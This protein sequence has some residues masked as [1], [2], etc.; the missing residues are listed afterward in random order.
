MKLF[1]TL[2]ALS[3]VSP[4]LADRTD[5]PTPPNDG[6]LG[7]LICK[8][9]DSESSKISK[10]TVIPIGDG[11]SGNAKVHISLASAPLPRPEPL[12]LD[13]TGTLTTDDVSLSFKGGNFEMFNYDASLFGVLNF[14]AVEDEMFECHWD[15]IVL[16]AGGVSN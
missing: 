9:F 10:V 5:R 12:V 6:F 13:A 1:L 2:I 4:A 16:P 15:V 7:K 14:D 8:P 11:K 3:F